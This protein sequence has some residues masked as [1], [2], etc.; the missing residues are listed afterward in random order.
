MEEGGSPWAEGLEGGWEEVEEE[1][2]GWEEAVGA[3]PWTEEE[4]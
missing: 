4:E 1:G 3:M 2:H